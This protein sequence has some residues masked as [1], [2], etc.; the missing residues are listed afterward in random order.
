MSPG[1]FRVDVIADGL[2]EAR[3]D[4]GLLRCGD[5]LLDG[6]IDERGAFAVEALGG[7]EHE[8][9]RDRPPGGDED[10]G[11]DA[12]PRALRRRQAEQ[13]ADE[14]GDRDEDHPRDDREPDDD[15]DG[16]GGCRP[17]AKDR[18]VHEVGPRT[19]DAH[20]DHAGR[21]P[22]HRLRP[23]LRRHDGDRHDDERCGDEEGLQRERPASAQALAEGRLV[24]IHR[25]PSDRRVRRRRGR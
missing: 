22:R 18:A 9:E 5:L 16:K 21:R 10:R 20:G 17:V 23:G 4:L 3:G 24:L 15:D 6:P 13:E 8:R 11:D 1:K 12:A 7:L 25:A 14:G 2:L 19:E